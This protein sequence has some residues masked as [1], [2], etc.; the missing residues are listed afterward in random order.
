MAFDFWKSP[1]GI[2][3]GHNMKTGRRIS[4][5]SPHTWFTREGWHLLFILGFVL[6]GAVL[7]NVNLLVLLAS[8]IAGMFVIQWR[9]CRRSL[10]HLSLR[11]QLPS[12]PQAGRPF[13]AKI[14]IENR[15]ILLPTWLICVE[16]RLE[17]IEPYPSANPI[18][19]TLVVP[20]VPAN[21][22]SV[23]GFQCQLLY[24]GKYRFNPA[25][26]STSFPFGLMRGWFTQPVTDHI[27]VR[28]KL[29]H[30]IGRWQNLI[31]AERQGLA[32]T[33]SRAGVNEGEFYGLRA[34]Q[35]GDSQRWI[36]WR[37]TAR[38][39]ELAVRQFEQQQKM[40][41]AILVDLWCPNDSS[42][43]NAPDPVIEKIISFVAT[44]LESMCRQG[45]HQIS[46]ALA[47]K[48]LRVATRI[49][50]RAVL[51]GALDDLAII[52]PTH[53]PDLLGAVEQMLPILA[54]NRSLLVISSRPAVTDQLRPP[55]RGENQR[56]I[57]EKVQVRWIN[58]AH[59]EL[60]P[61]FK[62]EDA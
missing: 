59:G 50:N 31:Q 45:N 30:L 21:Q 58:V 29:G 23:A 56:S 15:S 11:R 26:L 28:P 34:W 27:L 9:I 1:S 33:A 18:G 52:A 13:D 8:L 25:R 40:T 7:R 32:K 43:S 12:T 49:Q 3:T 39:N 20:W 6:L 60:D 24:R 41:L 4:A 22:V 48:H 35:H 14:Y 16:E 2:R 61:F 38:L 10:K 53:Q 46:L 55:I 5:N 36:H 37:T 57:M 42:K 17:C 51:H 19:T 54:D 62:M 44:F 47:G